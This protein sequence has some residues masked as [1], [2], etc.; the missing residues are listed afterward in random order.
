[1][2]QPYV[3]DGVVRYTAVFRPGT[4]AEYQVY[5]FS[6]NDYRQRYDDLWAQGYR[7]SMLQTYVP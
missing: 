3:V 2:I 5:G 6:Y 4:E 1:M 7:L